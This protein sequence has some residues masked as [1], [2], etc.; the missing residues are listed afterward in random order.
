MKSIYAQFGISKQAHF[1]AVKRQKELINNELLYV[2]FILDIRRIHPGMGLRLMYEQFDPE[3]IGRDAF[4]ALGLRHGFRL[5]VAANPVKTTKSVKHS[6]YPNMLVNKKLT[7]V[8]QLWVSD[9]FY[10]RLKDKHF[11][12]VLIM[13]VYSRRILGYSAADNMRAE[14]NVKALNM[15]LKLRGIKKYNK[16]LIHHSDRGSQY[17]SEAYTSLL[18]DYEI[19][20]SMCINVLDNSYSERVNGTIKN[21]Y[22]KLWPI[23][24]ELQLKSQFIHRAIESYNNRQHQS[25]GKKT[26]IEFETYVKELSSKERPVMKVFTVSNQN[27]ENPYQLSLFEGL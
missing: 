26:P 2:G 6:P 15:A 12:I 13:D 20:I 7:D 24:N 4:I 16:E 5:K 18:L 8:N 11:Y 27:S 25:L 14:Q 21:S 23:E 10:F 22:L 9:L 19:E 3:G 1:K 17:I